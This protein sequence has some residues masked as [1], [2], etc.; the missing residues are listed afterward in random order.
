MRNLIRW[1]FLDHESLVLLGAVSWSRRRPEREEPVG[2]ERRCA[3]ELAGGEARVEVA[4][5][6]VDPPPP[7][8]GH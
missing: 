8:A 2:G 4:N 1:G 3:V 6:E 7:R 5:K